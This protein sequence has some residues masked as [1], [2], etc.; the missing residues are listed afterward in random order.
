M[1]HYDD[2][3]EASDSEEGSAEKVRTHVGE[4]M[5]INQDMDIL[6]LTEGKAVRMTKVELKRGSDGRVVI[7]S[8]NPPRVNEGFLAKKMKI[9]ENNIIRYLDKYSKEKTINKIIN[10]FFSKK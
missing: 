8:G 3:F 9:N 5:R 4:L 10:K 6:G 2:F 1:R 7:V